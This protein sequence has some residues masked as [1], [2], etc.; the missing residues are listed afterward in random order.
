VRSYLTI[1]KYRFDDMVE[2][3]VD[4]PDGVGEYRIPKLVLQ[5]LLENSFK[6]AVELSVDVSVIQLKVHLEGEKLYVRIEDN[7]PG[8][9]PQILRRVREGEVNPK[10]TGI[11]LK[12]IDDR[13]KLYA[14]EE[15]GLRIENLSGK[16]TAIT[17]ILPGSAEVR[18]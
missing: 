3:V 8:I 5:P 18:T 17:V 14:G 15:Y 16:G 1:Q 12:N 9:D 10:G 11:G 13:I 4:V 6:H 2:F 7:G